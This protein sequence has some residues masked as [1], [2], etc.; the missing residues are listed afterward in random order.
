VSC[1]R[2][3]LHHQ[4]HLEKT[5]PVPDHQTGVYL[6][7]EIPGMIPGDMRDMFFDADTHALNPRWRQGVY[8]TRYGRLDTWQHCPGCKPRDATHGT[9]CDQCHH[10]LVEWLT[11]APALF[12]WLTANLP[13][14]NAAGAK[15]DWQ[16][17]ATPDGPPAPIRVQ[18][19]DVRNLLADRLIELEDSVRD[20]F[21]LTPRQ[22]AGGPT[23]TRASSTHG[24]SSP[25][26]ASAEHL[27]R[28]RSPVSSN[29]NSE[30]TTMASSQFRGR[31]RFLLEWLPRVEQDSDEI[32][33]QFD[34]LE[35]VYRRA[36]TL[37]PWEDRPRRVVGIS[38]PECDRNT[39]EVKP[40]QED[41]TCRT[42]RAV[43]DRHRY[44]IWV[45][46]LADD[47]STSMSF[48]G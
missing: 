20:V 12:E 1:S 43:I 5:C 47:A 13:P 22:G 40:G 38:C 37:V 4:R 11:N 16:R 46:I 30:I 23:R 15:R 34:L 44:E 18:V 41:V 24:P 14:G 2:G 39:L 27:T 45:R 19:L 25:P 3:C 33:H 29:P 31:C 28:E 17:P 7:L 26:N 9:V 21:N 35:D 8:V 6:A 42:C 48:A 36:R 10:R 32:R